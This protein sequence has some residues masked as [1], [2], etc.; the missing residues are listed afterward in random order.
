MGT[1][2]HRITVTAGR[3]L[4]R[5]LATCADCGTRVPDGQVMCSACANK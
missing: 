3:L 1:R 2:L 5:F 4:A